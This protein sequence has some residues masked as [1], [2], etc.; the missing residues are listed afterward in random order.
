MN[1]V[2]EVT[3]ELIQTITRAVRTWKKETLP[4][5]DEEQ[6]FDTFCEQEHGLRVEFGQHGNNVLILG[7]EILDED[8]Y[9]NFLL[10]F[11]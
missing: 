10:R 11:G 7:A 6:H 2:V 4:L 5:D 9:I 1:T 3:P 8:K